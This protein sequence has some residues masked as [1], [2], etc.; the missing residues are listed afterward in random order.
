MLKVHQETNTKC[1]IPPK[2]AFWKWYETARAEDN[3]QLA[4]WSQCKC[5]L[6]R[7]QI[8]DLNDGPV[9]PDSETIPATLNSS[10]SSTGSTSGSED[11]KKESA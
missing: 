1:E 6:Q 11:E 2:Q 7:Q 8:K 5:F 9:K 4:Q 10:H 3:T